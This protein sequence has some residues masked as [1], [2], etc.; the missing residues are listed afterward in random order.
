MG[1]GHQIANPLTQDDSSDESTEEESI[2]P[3]DEEWY[4]PGVEGYDDVLL[5][6]GGGPDPDDPNDSDYVD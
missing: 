6:W 5:G 4:E 1:Q 2:E 3:S